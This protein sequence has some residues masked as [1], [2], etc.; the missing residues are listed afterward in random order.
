[1]NMFCEKFSKF[2]I[3]D[4]EM[5]HLDFRSNSCW[6]Y[7]KASTNIYFSLKRNPRLDGE[8]D[9]KFKELAEKI[10]T[11]QTSS[12]SP[13]TPRSTSELLT[14]KFP[15]EHPNKAGGS[16]LW[17]SIAK[18]GNSIW[19]FLQICLISCAPKLRRKKQPPRHKWAATGE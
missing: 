15:S 19:W 17:G 11:F 10:A 1:M 2:L 12:S 7:L 16:K 13:I 6:K 4:L 5:L 14:L 9:A 18:V 8:T 3:N